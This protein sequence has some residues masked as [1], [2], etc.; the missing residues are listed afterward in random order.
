MEAGLPSE[1][2][3]M[4]SVGA[5]RC[6]IFAPSGE[7]ISDRLRSQ[8]DARSWRWT[9]LEDSC[10]AMA[11]LCLQE[12]NQ[13][14]RAS[15]GLRR[16]EQLALVLAVPADGAD[17]ALEGE[18]SGLVSAVQRYLPAVP[19]WL[20]DGQD[21][22]LIADGSPPIGRRP[23]SPPRAEPCASQ[24]E[25]TDLRLADPEPDDAPA[26]EEEVDEGLDGEPA[27]ITVE[28]IEMLFSRDADE[29][30]AR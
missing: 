25:A 27:Q 14:S 11:E 16:A 13:S 1:S 15:W 8:P 23:E 4:T 6:I 2:P 24:P 7:A 20:L 10:A 3:N 28:E 26:P 5:T 9:A 18:L 29:A 17:E 19:I 12:K 22:S 21:L 30:S